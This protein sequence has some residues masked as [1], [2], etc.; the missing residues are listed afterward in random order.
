MTDPKQQTIVSSSS[1]FFWLW[2]CTRLLL[3]IALG[4][5]SIAPAPLPLLK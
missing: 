1:N 2:H 5:V 3:H 4:A